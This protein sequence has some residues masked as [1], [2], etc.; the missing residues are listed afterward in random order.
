MMSVSREQTML[1]ARQQA[2]RHA[3]MNDVPEI[4]LE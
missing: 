3:S 1:A 4:T 2:T